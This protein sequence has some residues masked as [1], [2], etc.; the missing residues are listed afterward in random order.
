MPLVELAVEAEARGFDA[1]FVPEHTHIPTARR[2]PY[3]DG[4]PLPGRYLRLWDPHVAL[5]FV[6]ARTDLVVGTCVALVGQ[7]DPIAYAKAVAT[8]DHHSGGRAVV[9]IGFGWN[10]EEFEDH[11]YPPDRRWEVVAEKVRL[12][13]QLWAEEE[14]SFDGK[15]VRLSPSWAWPKPLQRPHPPVLIGGLPTHARSAVSLHGRTAGSR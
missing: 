9:G 14:A 12:M 6:A 15:W 4:S 7:H 5:S 1:A 2:T 8:L 10:A 13:Q 3:P 11:G